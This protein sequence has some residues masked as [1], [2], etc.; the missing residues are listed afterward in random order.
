MPTRDF[1]RELGNLRAFRGEYV[2]NDLLER[3][4]EAGLLRPRIRVRYPDSIA[5]RFWLKKHNTW[6]CQLKLPVEPDGPRWNAAVDFANALH[7]WRN[8]QTYGSPPNPIDDPPPRFAQFIQNPKDLTFEG[9]NARRVDVSS[10]KYETLVDDEN[11]ED[12][13][14]TWQVLLAAEM[15]DAGIHIR[16]NLADADTAAMAEG[17]RNGRIPNGTGCSFNFTSVHA[18]QDFAKHE[19][20]LDCVVWFAEECS[21]ALSHIVLKRGGS[22][23]RMSAEEAD[24]YD[25][26]RHEMAVEA[27]RRFDVAETD[28]IALMTFLAKYWANWNR[29]GRPKIADGYKDVLGKAVILTREITGVKFTELRDRIGRVGGH[30]KPI[31]DV[32]W[33]NWAEEEKERAR[34]TLKAS[35][36]SESR[37]AL[38]V[39]DADID[40]FVEFLAREGLEAFFWRL[41]SFE[42]HAL[43]GN[44]FALE[45]MRS[46]IQGMS[47][48]VE[49]VAAV[50]GGNKTQLFEKF[51][52]LWH[53]TTVLCILKRGDVAPLARTAKLA[54]DWLALKDSIRALQTEPGGAIA[55]DLVMAH[56]IRGGVHNTLPEHD[57][58]ELERL[59]VG[60]MRA[61]L[62]TFVEVRRPSP[63]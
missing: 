22:R 32:I 42:D 43:R 6:K 1:I 48:A 37:G 44:E 56:R 15:A 19:K 50:L 18:A 46:D 63:A 7:R 52:Q 57:H 49:H 36:P 40:A 38:N 26:S 13:Y 31:L 24:E 27:I 51:K 21:R 2:G 14:T 35:I 3:L 58:F 53:D 12:Y 55:A 30:F 5:R 10:D 4:E 60:L 45:G 47:I 9:W 41:K 34:L 16:I 11:V 28:L 39:T 23:F 61:A 20:V 8:R 54:D 62:L 17:L 59:F 25:R 29:D 33:P